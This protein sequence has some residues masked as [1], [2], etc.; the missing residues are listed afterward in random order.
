MDRERSL[1]AVAKITS[2]VGLA[3]DVRVTLLCESPA[4][5]KKITA[6]FV[7]RTAERA[8]PVEIASVK[9]QGNGVLIRFT[10]IDDRTSSDVFRNQFVFID[11]ADVKPPATGAYPIDALIGC[12][13][14]TVD[15]KELG[16]I[17]DVYSLPGNDVWTVWTGSEEVMV[18][19]VR[20][21]VKRV[22]LTAR[23]VVLTPVEGLFS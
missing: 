16:T 17:R 18:P 15:G 10:G 4:R 23:V 5:L 20:E 14:T 9:V 1:T 3:G 22:D 11:S 8:R 12:A 6:A 19:A 7:G 2:S 13:V 21:W